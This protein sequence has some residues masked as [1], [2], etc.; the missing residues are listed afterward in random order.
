MPAR[1]CGAFQVADTSGEG[2]TAPRLIVPLF[3]LRGGRRFEAN[4]PAV[5]PAILLPAAA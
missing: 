5:P 4:K 2:V 3:C 1:R